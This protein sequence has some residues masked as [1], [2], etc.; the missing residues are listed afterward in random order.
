MIGSNGLNTHSRHQECQAEYHSKSTPG[1]AAYVI[2]SKESWLW[3]CGDRNYNQPD[4]LSQRGLV[5]K[6]V[7]ELTTH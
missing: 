4:R 2:P 6:R 7:C 5:S 3:M 1:D